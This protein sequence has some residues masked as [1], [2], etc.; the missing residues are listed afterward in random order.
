MNVKIKYKDEIR[1]GEFFECPLYVGGYGIKLKDGTKMSALLPEYL[2]EENDSLV[3]TIKHKIRVIQLVQEFVKE[4]EERAVKH[5]NSKLEENEKPYFDTIRLKLKGLTYGTPE[6]KQSLDELKPALDHH[7][8]NNSHHPEH[9]ENGI[10]YMD[11]FDVIE[12]FFDWKAASERHSDG[13]I[14]QSIRHNHGR[15][16]M[17]N[18]LAWIFENTA[19]RLN[20]GKPEDIIDNFFNNK[21]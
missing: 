5:D 18:Q 8:A 21:E 9:Y 4:L 11:L 17:S 15:F 6:Y 16:Q 19:K 7:Y 10:N 13:N 14:Y 3:D 20:W 1:E 2:E 12:M